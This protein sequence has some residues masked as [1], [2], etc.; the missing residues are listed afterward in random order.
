MNSI[1]QTNQSEKQLSEKMQYFL[2]ADI[3]RIAA[4]YQFVV[5]DIF[6]HMPRVVLSIVQSGISKP[7]VHIVIF[8]WI[9]EASFAERFE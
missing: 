1:A 4:S 7:D 8:V 9:F 2:H 3:Y 6:H 5:D